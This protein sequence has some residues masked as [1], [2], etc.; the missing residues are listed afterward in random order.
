MKQKQTYPNLEP[1]GYTSG[2]GSFVS[3]LGNIPPER[4]SL[5][6]YKESS[7]LALG[8]TGM[9]VAP[10]G[11]GKTQLLTQLAISI[12]SG[13]DFLNKFH[14]DYPGHVFLC[15]GEEDN[16]EVHRRIHHSLVALSAKSQ[17]E[18]MSKLWA[19]GLASYPLALIEQMDIKLQSTIKRDWVPSDAFKELY[20]LLEK[21]A[22]DRAFFWRLIILE[23]ASRFMGPVAEADNGVATKFVQILE[24]FTTLPGA[25]V[26][27]IAH[28]ANKGST[29]GETDQTAARGSSALTDGVRWQANLD[30]VSVVDPETKKLK[31]EHS[32]ID[33][34]V[35]KWN[36]GR[37]PPVV[38]LERIDNGVLVP[39]VNDKKEAK[40]VLKASKE[41]KNVSKL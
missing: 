39:R 25:P 8:T 22:L 31:V 15:C 26:V 19:Q 11:V 32:F 1:G 12:S 27:L 36:Y 16:H 35:V 9:L 33:F 18:A 6:S 7:M 34:R 29:K 13:E 28:H 14:V 17:Q 3:F 4:R 2:R 5:L 21:T 38:E 41:K 24:Q 20:Q 37:L 23:P 30:R 40:E 10:G